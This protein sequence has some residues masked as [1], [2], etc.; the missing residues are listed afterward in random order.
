MFPFFGKKPPSP[1]DAPPQPAAPTE[2]PFNPTLGAYE[3]NELGSDDGCG[4]ACSAVVEEAAIYFANDLPEQAVATLTRHLRDNPGQKEIQ[5]WLMLFD[6]YQM[7]GRKPQFHELALQFAEKFERSAP[8]WDKQ[9]ERVGS[10]ATPPAPT[11]GGSID[12]PRVLDANC[13]PL[14][15]RLRQLAQTGARLE[16]GG[17]EKLEAA[18]SEL[19]CRTLQAL[20]KAGGGIR[21]DGAERLAGRA[22]KS[23]SSEAGQGHWL[24][25]LELYQWLGK[26]AEFEETAIEYAVTFEVSPPSWEM[27]EPA[28]TR[29]E[30]PNPAAAAEPEDV[31][32]LRGV[33]SEASRQ[34][35]KELIAYAADR[36]EVRLDMAAVTRVEFTSVGMFL[37]E[38]TEL[39]RAGK[40]V[41]ISEANEMVQALL[42]TMGAAQFATLLKKKSH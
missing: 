9:Q 42:R 25:L 21:L 39:D 35:L 3:V 41:V 38:L 28:A 29:R 20:R 15:Q 14:L 31:F 30:A 5:P 7:L 11:G 13:E 32:R 24:L 27:P 16:L 37:T 18:G 33:I 22:R 1:A 23:A 12:L 10:G 19:F 2:M 34:Q 6:L 4:E 8:P 36:T 17:I 40:K 26:E